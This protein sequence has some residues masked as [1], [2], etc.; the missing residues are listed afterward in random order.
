MREIVYEKVNFPET[1]R[2]AFVELSDE[3]IEE[4]YEKIKQGMKRRGLDCLIIY[5]DK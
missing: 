1:D 4:R 5:A 2:Q 3:T